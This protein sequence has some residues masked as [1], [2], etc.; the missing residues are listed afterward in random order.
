MRLLKFVGYKDYQTER[1][2]RQDSRNVALT[3]NEVE[4]DGLTPYTIKMPDCPK[5]EKIINF[6]LPPEEQYFKREEIPEWVWA[7]SRQAMKSPEERK[8]IIDIASSNSEYATFIADQWDKRVN[9]IFIYIYGQ[10]C[11]IP[12]HYWWWLNYYVIDVGLADYRFVD[13]EHAWW[14]KFCIVENYNVYG[15]IEFTMRRDGKS[16]RAFG[17]QLEYT[18]R[19]REA[20]A[21]SQSKVNET[22]RALFGQK[23]VNPWRQLPFYFNPKFDNKSFP[24]KEINF[25]D[26]SSGEDLDFTL[27]NMDTDELLSSIQMKATVEHAFDNAKLHRYVFDEGGKTEEVSI[28][29]TW[30]VVKQCL[31][32]RSEIVGKALLPT[33]VEET[34]KYGLKEFKKVWDDS[35]HAAS[36]LTA[37]G[38]TR[39]GLVRFFKPAWETYVFDQYGHSI[40]GKPLAFQQRWLEAQPRAKVPFPDKGGREL[41]DIE[42]NSQTDPTDRLKAE[43]MYPRSIRAAFRGDP[44]DCEFNIQK[45]NDQLDKYLY[46]NDDVV[47]GNLSWKDGVPD[48][49]VI[50]TEDKLKGR[51]LFDK[52]LLPFLLERANKVIKRGKF[53]YPGNKGQGLVGAD[54]YKYD[55]TAS[56]R[57]SLG[58]GHGYIGFDI[59]IEDK[60]EGEDI[61]TDNYC[62]EYGHRWPDKKR[63]GED[64]IMTCFFLGWEMFPEI[65]APFIWDYFV[66][67]G[68][69]HFLK[70]RS[71]IKK[72]LKGQSVKIEKAKTPGMTT[73]G[74]TIKEPMFTHMGNYIEHNAHR[75]K[76]VKLLED[77]RDVE[78]AKL[79]PYDYFVSSAY[80]LYGFR[81]VSRPKQKEEEEQS[82]E[83]S[84]MWKPTRV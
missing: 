80:A 9:G 32:V 62:F 82:T 50:W 6:G 8:R 43:R 35:D 33:T 79:N 65:N 57:K 25:R 41:V 14:W 44:K 39:S 59:D 64:M 56:E 55:A 30:R 26:A 63:Y 78:Y 61:L 69:E 42:I 31:R 16:Y 20:I 12:G 36:E 45:I 27:E 84:M 22:A 48:I 3:D 2:L 52:E 83:G 4:H 5:V 51:W 53:F 67:R 77:C 40:I 34:T 66:E 76:F 15:G 71:V 18:T 11:Y 46:K 10:I 47:K 28:K 81:G 38:Q 19:T 54:P 37:T 60:W 70:Y 58:T 13:L 23:V 72:R 7:M 21:G 49:E 73:L 24:V 29:E 75:C 1:I 68:Y 74:D 17:E